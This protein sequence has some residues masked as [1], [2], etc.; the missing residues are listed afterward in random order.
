[1][2]PPKDFWEGL[3]GAVADKKD[4]VVLVGFLVSSEFSDEVDISV[5]ECIVEPVR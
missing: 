3:I 4:P 1:M 2:R 5:R